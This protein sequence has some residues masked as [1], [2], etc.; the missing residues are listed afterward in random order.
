MKE[1]KQT[2]E[3][4]LFLGERFPKFE[5]T[6]LKKIGH[7]R[8]IRRAHP[9]YTLI[10]SRGKKNRFRAYVTYGVQK[11][12][13]NRWRDWTGSRIYSLECDR[14]REAIREQANPPLRGFQYHP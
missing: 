4:R 12:S 14:F 11:W 1:A 13:K 9:G 7:V 5:Q 3:V 8:L 6:V 2:I 10:S